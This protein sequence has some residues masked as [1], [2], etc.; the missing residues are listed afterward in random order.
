M[1][2]ER[3]RY[4]DV[5]AEFIRDDKEDRGTKEKFWLARKS[6]GAWFLFKVGH[7]DAEGNAVEHWAEVAAAELCEHLSIPHA[8]YRLAVY[9]GQRGTISE[10][11]RHLHFPGG[12]KTRAAFWMANHALG[13]MRERYPVDKRRGVK[14]YTVGACIDLLQTIA[15]EAT[16]HRAA[17]TQTVVSMPDLFC[18][19]LMLDA[20]IANSDRHHENWGFIVAQRGERLWFELAPTFDHAASFCREPAKKVRERLQTADK[21]RRVEAFCGSPKAKSAFFGEDGRPLSPLE[22]FREAGSRIPGGGWKLWLD[23]LR[24]LNPRRDLTFAFGEG[25]GDDVVAP[26]S[27]EFALQMVEVNRARLLK[28]AKQRYN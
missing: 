15:A 22:A 5:S 12:G 23:N 13:G 14:E 3:C 2:E 21:Q 9:N 24:K 18:G 11:F 20:L 19:Y 28:L 6:D 27:R 16:P 8:S 10:D 7:I 26:A 4:S 25:C 1:S 17:K